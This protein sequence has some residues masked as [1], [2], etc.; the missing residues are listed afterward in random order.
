[1]NFQYDINGVVR[2]PWEKSG[3]ITYARHNNDI[4]RNKSGSRRSLYLF[5]IMRF[6]SFRDRDAKSSLGFVVSSINSLFVLLKLL[7]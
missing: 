1:M 7:V 3:G 4:A 2:L 5:P 6:M